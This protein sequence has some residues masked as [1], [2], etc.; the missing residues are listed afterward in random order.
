MSHLASN[1]QLF[2][3]LVREGSSISLA[4]VV[5][6]AIFLPRQVNAMP[7]KI[8]VAK[9]WPLR[10]QFWSGELDDNYLQLR[11]VQRIEVDRNYFAT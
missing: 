8:E 10:Q 1:G 4:R 2:P 5:R 9:H 3:N 7:C 6:S 11:M